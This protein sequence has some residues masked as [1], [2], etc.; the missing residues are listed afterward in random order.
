[1]DVDCGK[2]LQKVLKKKALPF[3]L[4]M[5]GYLVKATKSKVVVEYKQNGSEE[6]KKPKQ[7]IVWL[8]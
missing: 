2:E 4:I 6:V 1:M 5:C 7:T 8:R 3:I